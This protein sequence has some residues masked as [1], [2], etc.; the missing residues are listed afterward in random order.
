MASS[1]EEMD[2]D[3]IEIDP[4]TLNVVAGGSGELQESGTG[5]IVA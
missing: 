4:S 2:L 1:S 3:A 5:L